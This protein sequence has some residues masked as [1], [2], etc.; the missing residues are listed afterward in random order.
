M[1]TYDDSSQEHEP[2]DIYVSDHFA[3]MVADALV[4]RMDTTIGEGRGYVNVTLHADMYLDE[5]FAR[6]RN[7]VIYF[8]QKSEANRMHADDIAQIRAGRDAQVAE[9]DETSDGVV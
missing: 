7:K 2:T 4:Y 9:L 6:F 3:K 1:A 5:W 8:A